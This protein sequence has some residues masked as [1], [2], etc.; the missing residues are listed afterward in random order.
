M[1]SHS[2]ESAEL[3]SADVS[4]PLSEPVCSWS[5]PIDL[6]HLLIALKQ[7]K[8]ERR[9]GERESER[10]DTILVQLILYTSHYATTHS[11]VIDSE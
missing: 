11:R 4:L 3:S 1:I 10:K 6:S 7:D 8:R 9:V 2:V 5:V